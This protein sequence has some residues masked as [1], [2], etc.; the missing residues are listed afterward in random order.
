MPQWY[1]RSD[2]FAFPSLAEGSACVTYEAMAAGLP[3]VV[4][5]ESGS[6][7]RDAQDGFVIP[8]ADPDALADRLRHLHARP[9]LRAAM[10][11]SARAAI[12]QRWTW[13]HYGE[14]V[15]AVWREL[16]A[17]QEA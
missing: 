15:V 6:V 14:R 3:S 2:V 10:G 1:A 5:A 7:V 17:E 8:A 11:A 16:L 4:T 12:E 13:R 9:D